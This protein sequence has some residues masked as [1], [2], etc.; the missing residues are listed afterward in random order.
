MNNYHLHIFSVAQA[1]FYS[2]F[3]CPLNCIALREDPSTFYI[4][5]CK[6]CVRGGVQKKV[7][8]A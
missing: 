5:T 1:V 3:F 4:G 7:R 6:E 2:D 8:K